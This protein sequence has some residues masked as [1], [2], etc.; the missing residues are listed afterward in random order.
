MK[1]DYESNFYE[2]YRGYGFS[3]KATNLFTGFS[4]RF[5]VAAVNKEG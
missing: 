4:Y 2:I 3:F 1:P 5:K